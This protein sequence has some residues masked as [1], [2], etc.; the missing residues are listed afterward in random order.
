MRS[1]LPAIR[2]HRRSEAFH[3]RISQAKTGNVAILRDIVGM[4]NGAAA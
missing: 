1:M 3:E 4:A 2:E